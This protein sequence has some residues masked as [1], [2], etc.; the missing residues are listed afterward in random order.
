MREYRGGFPLPSTCAGRITDRAICRLG[1][2]G[3]RF[4]KI[5]SP[6]SKSGDHRPRLPDLHPA[7]NESLVPIVISSRKS[8]NRANLGQAAIELPKPIPVPNSQERR[9]RHSGLAASAGSGICRQTHASAS[10]ADTCGLFRRRRDIPGT[11]FQNRLDPIRTARTRNFMRSRTAAHQTAR[12]VWIAQ[13]YSTAS[14]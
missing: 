1:P 5:K 7:G 12:H 13:P 6:I 3:A 11:H 9:P 8:M 14:P 4:R 10:A 2:G